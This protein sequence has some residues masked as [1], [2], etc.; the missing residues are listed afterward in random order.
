MITAKVQQKYCE[1]VAGV[2]TNMHQISVKTAST[3][4]APSNTIWSDSN[5]L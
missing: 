1:T 5:I 2:H 4:Q 3:A